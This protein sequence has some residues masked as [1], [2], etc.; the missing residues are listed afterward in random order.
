MF[1]RFQRAA[2]CQR[3]HRAAAR[4][5]FNGNDPEVF[6][7]GEQHRHRAPVLVADLFVGEA[8]EELDVASCQPFEPLT[9]RSITRDAKRGS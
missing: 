2:A 8:A 5:R 4:L 7:A 3:H 1:D 6:F 9:I